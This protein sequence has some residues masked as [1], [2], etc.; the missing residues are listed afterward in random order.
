MIA[1]YETA[2]M[3]LGGRGHVLGGCPTLYVVT[4]R[5]GQGQDPGKAGVSQGSGVANA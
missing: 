3:V 2:G 5:R 4:D 1:R